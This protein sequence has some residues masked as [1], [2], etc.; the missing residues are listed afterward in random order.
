MIRELESKID[1]ILITKKEWK[2]IDKYRHQQ[3]PNPQDQW[4]TN[5]KMDSRMFFPL[6]NFI[7]ETEFESGSRRKGLVE[8][9]NFNPMDFTYTDEIGVLTAKRATTTKGFVISFEKHDSSVVKAP[10]DY[11]DMLLIYLTSVM[12]YIIDKA[13]ERR[14]IEKLSPEEER[15]Q[16]ENYEYKDRELFFLQD[17]IKY[18]RIHPNKSAIQY[19]CECWGVRGHLRHLKNGNVIFIEPYK[20]GRKRDILEPK[21]KTYL[22]NSKLSAREESEEE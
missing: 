15:K 13:E 19:R 7:L 10:K 8:L 18:R 11:F 2:Q 12:I 6:N 17:I 9:N 5:G 3:N 22:V 14:R 1:K 16:R 4:N 21:N 20:K